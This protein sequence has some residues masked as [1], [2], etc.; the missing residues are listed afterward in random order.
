MTDALRVILEIGKKRR[1]VAGAMDWPGLDR[2]GTSEDD[3]TRQAAPRTSRGTPASPSGPA[4]GR[5]RAGA[6]RRGGRARARFELD[7]LL[8]HRPRALG[9][10]ARG[11]VAGRPGAAARPAA[12][13][14]GLLRRRRGTRLRRAPAR[15]SQRRAQSRPDHP[16]RVRQRAR[17]VLPQG[18]GPDPARRR[19]HPEGPRDASA[20]IPRCHPRLQRRGQA[21]AHLADPVPRPPYRPPRH[22]SCVGDGGPDVGP[23]VEPGEGLGG[24]PERPAARCSTGG[25][26]A[27]TIPSQRGAAPRTEAIGAS[28]RDAGHSTRSLGR[29]AGPSQV[30]ARRSP[31]LD[32]ARDNA[33][34]GLATDR[35]GAR[36]RALHPDRAPRR[37]V[38]HRD[39][40]RVGGGRP[41][42]HR[43]PG[44]RRRR[45]SH[46]GGPCP[47][48][49]RI[50]P[51]HAHRRALDQGRLDGQ[52]RG[53][54][55][56]QGL[57]RHRPW[58]QP[59]DQHAP[60]PPAATGGR[61]LVDDPGGVGPLPRTGGR[62]GG[63]DLH[64]PSTS[65]R[66]DTPAAT[67]APSSRS[68]TTA[69]LRR[70]PTGSERPSPSGRRN[71]SP[72]TAPD[73]PRRHRPDPRP[74]LGVRTRLGRIGGAVE[75]R[76]TPE[77]LLRGIST[78]W[79]QKS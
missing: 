75:E 33:A 62:Q 3:A 77:R 63:A 76:P 15:T 70:T 28:R 64:A 44:P 58:L 22:G 16:P 14:L 52:R 26:A 6:R 32:L 25:R 71:R 79:P 43:V 46:V 34:R 65:S 12:G 60:D 35:R 42:P 66:I 48:P 50:R 45:R 73:R 21:G 49:S 61:R 36:G 2:W 47:R 8:G 20:G 30:A 37:S 67:S 13:L 78:A 53:R 56:A 31:P 17:A 23:V 9:D 4:W 27:G 41:G 29:A 68:M 5:V 74:G 59:V 39:R 51:A 24:P 55:D 7:R 19:P 18:R 72:S 57:H 40:A 54:E 10:R 69:S 11:A 38:A 1:V